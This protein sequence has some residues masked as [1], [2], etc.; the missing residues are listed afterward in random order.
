MRNAAV[1]GCLTVRGCG[2]TGTG[3][4]KRNFAPS[5]K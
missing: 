1:G 3:G 5:Y 4:K 2:G